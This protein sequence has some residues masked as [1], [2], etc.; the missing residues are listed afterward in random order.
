M[1]VLMCWCVWC[2]NVFDVLMCW[3]IDVLMCLMCW[4]VDVLMY[5]M[6]WWMDCVDVLMILCWYVDDCVKKWCV[7][8]RVWR[9]VAMCWGVDNNY[10]DVLIMWCVDVLI[11]WVLTGYWCVWYLYDLRPVRL[12]IITVETSVPNFLPSMLSFK[13]RGHLHS[14]M[15]FSQFQVF[16]L[17]WWK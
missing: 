14:L 16:F 12:R 7:W 6:C 8:W 15:R 2:V 5:L 4:C 9:V 10:V 11:M 3:C 1:I 13:R 17:E